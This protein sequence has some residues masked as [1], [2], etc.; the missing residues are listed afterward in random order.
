MFGYVIV[1]NDEVVYT[2]KIVRKG[3]NMLKDIYETAKSTSAAA[4]VVRVGLRAWVKKYW[5]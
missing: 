1:V 2:V 3:R 4:T 5:K